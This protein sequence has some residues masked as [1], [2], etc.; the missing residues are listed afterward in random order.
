MSTERQTEVIRAQLISKAVLRPDEA[1]FYELTQLAGVTVDPKI[2][3][4]LLDLLK[5]NVPPAAIVQTLRSM[6]SPHSDFSDHLEDHYHPYPS[7]SFPGGSGEPHGSITSHSDTSGLRRHGGMSTD[8]YRNS[9]SISGERRAAERSAAE[10]VGSSG[11]HSSG[12]ASSRENT[13]TQTEPST[14]SR[15]R[16]ASDSQR[17]R[18][19]DKRATSASSLSYAD[20]FVT[21]RPRKSSAEVSTLKDSDRLT[22]KRN[23]YR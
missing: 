2:F 14:T 11:G 20:S 18:P 9:R 12:V 17:Q 16:Y 13:R 7:S 6:C 21:S 5:M 15:P 19:Q 3:K 10:L 4:I 1:E 23:S 8:H 22:K